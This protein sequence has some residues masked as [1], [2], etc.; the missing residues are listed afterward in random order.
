MAAVAFAILLLAIRR[1]DTLPRLLA[2][3]IVL[4][5]LGLETAHRWIGI[6]FPLAR[7]GLYIVPVLTLSVL[8]LVQRMHWKPAEWLPLV[9]AFA[10]IFQFNPNRYG[11]WPEYSGARD[12]IKAIRRDAPGR[13]VRIAASAGLD[14]VLNYYRVR[15]ALGAWAPVSDALRSGSVEYYALTPADTTLVAE[16][17]LHVIWRDAYLTVAR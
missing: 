3:T 10:Y 4:S 6:P 7:S 9:L 16:R 5:F 11:E 17:N 13:P 1:D 14:H 8:S 15:Y 2:G 12:V